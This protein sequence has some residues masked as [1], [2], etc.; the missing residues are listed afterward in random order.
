[1]ILERG[2]DHVARNE[3]ERKRVRKKHKAEDGNRKEKDG[4][5]FLENPRPK[6]V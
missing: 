5:S 3:E 1:M 2:R 6:K 4:E